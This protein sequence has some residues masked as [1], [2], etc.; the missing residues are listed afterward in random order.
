MI[1]IEAMAHGLPVVALN[2]GSTVDVVPHQEC[3]ILIPPNSPEE[4]ASELIKLSDKRESLV[5]M[6]NNGKIWVLEK[7]QPDNLVRNI[8]EIIVSVLKS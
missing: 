4:L 7:F 2:N 1:F 3:G 8:N 6:G 5:T